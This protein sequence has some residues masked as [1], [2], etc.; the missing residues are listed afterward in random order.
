MTRID[1]ET[2]DEI[3][4][5]IVSKCLA[6]MNGCQDPKFKHSVEEI[7]DY[8]S[9]WQFSQFAFFGEVVY[10]RDFPIQCSLLEAHG[11]S[12]SRPGQLGLCVCPNIIIMQYRAYA[13]T[14]CTLGWS[15]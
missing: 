9:D 5:K 3:A 12:R 1:N 13:C 2:Y 8:Q 6:L 15:I 7:I 14:V 10:W 4:M 11:K